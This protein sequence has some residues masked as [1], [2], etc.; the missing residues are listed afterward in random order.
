MVKNG[1]GVNLE[2]DIKKLSQPMWVED[3]WKETTRCE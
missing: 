3:Y 1:M 2:G